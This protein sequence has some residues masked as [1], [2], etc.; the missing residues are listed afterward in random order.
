[1]NCAHHGKNDKDIYGYA[2]AKGDED[3]ARY[4]FP[5]RDDF[6]GSHRN[7]VEANV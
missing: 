7:K 4:G 1:M 2:N 5:G 3:S 6:L